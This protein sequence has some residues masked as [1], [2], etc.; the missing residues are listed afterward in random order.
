MSEEIRRAFD[1]ARSDVAAAVAHGADPDDVLLNH[2]NAVDDIVRG[3]FL[4]ALDEKLAAGVALIALGGYG[5]RELTPGSDLDLL[6]LHRGWNQSDV[7]EVNRALMYPL[8]DAGREL[9]DRVR[10]PDDVFRS[11]GRVDEMAAV[12]DARLLAGDEVLFAEL[13]AGVARRLERGRSSFF[14]HLVMASTARHERFGHAGHLLE[15]NLRDS[16]GGLRDL[17]TLWW[18]SRVLPGTNGF[19][20]LI[21]SGML[22]ALDG[23][24]VRSA[25][26]FLLDVR[27]RLHLLTGRH[28]DQ[29]YLLEQDQIALELG[30]GDE[31]HPRGDV[32][33]QELYRHARSVD[34][35]VTAFWE[36]V[37]HRKPRRVWRST[38]SSAIGD[39][40]LLQDGRLEVVAV[41][42]PRNDPAAWL[43]VFRRSIRHGAPLSRTSLNR[44]QESLR[45][46]ELTWSPEARE[47]F[48][49]VI[50]SGAAGVRALESMDAS[51]F[52]VA[53]VPEWQGIRC[54]PQRDLYHRFTV[55]MHLF[56]A[57][58][59]LAASRVSDEPVVRDAWRRI[60]D[61]DALFVGVLLHD[62]GKGRGGDHSDIGVELAVSAA[63]RMGLENA[64]VADVEFLVREHL[65][66]ARLAVHRDLNDQRTIDEATSRA[67]DARRLAM[68]YLITRAD[69]IA[70]G[71]EAWS[72]FRAMLV[73]EL[74][75]K[76]LAALEGSRPPA[77][78]PPQPSILDEPLAPDEI[79]TAVRTVDES[80]EFVVVAFD[81]PG[82]FAT[83]CGALALRGIDIHDAEIYTRDDDVAV[84]VF[85]V[86]GSHG[87]VP[88]ER[89]ER[90]EA[91]VRATLAGELDLD[92]A[93][94]RKS[95]QARRRRL[96]L[97]K[98]GP[99]RVVVAE[100]A[101]ETHTV[102]EVHAE[103]R[104]GLLREITKAL[105][106]AGCDLSLAKVATY[107]TDVVDVFYVRDLNGARITDG[108][109]L[110]R[111]EARLRRLFASPVR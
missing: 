21:G 12:V 13:E 20:G 106:D 111:I 82:L 37:T 5:R 90:V 29:L 45:G 80:Y 46:A 30:Y 44:L 108:E 83:V 101:S 31:A 9:G 52:L 40:C 73:R 62:I 19:A 99:A 8:W 56:A 86:V 26:R 65:T 68:L 36:R 94:A 15:P 41:T 6:L 7:A 2:A 96:P 16:A 27:I 105:Y 48:L 35:I 71:P 91:D 110:N 85:R 3:A 76:T 43:R 54:L 22:S 77:V 87:A 53:L 34:A 25:R 39:G 103:D 66:L 42:D 57:L 14:K 32:F 84:E 47:I 49:E 79:R 59:E 81:R 61:A 104:L 89:W 97:D 50:Q 98:R 51:G 102:I 93:L 75:S 11:F 67:G 78:A 109:H 58:A 60:G 64:Q 95:A 28:Q 74:Y 4:R 1:A 38:G 63:G 55:D 69:S 18:A 23:D 70:T 10:A 100:D 33:M 17:H 88:D 92:E 24:I 107:G 72:S